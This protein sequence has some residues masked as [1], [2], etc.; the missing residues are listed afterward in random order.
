MTPY[1]S[2]DYT[3]DC[4]REQARK[5]RESGKYSKVHVHKARPE[6]INGQ[7]VEYGRVYV[8]RKES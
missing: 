5:C 4:C 6:R 3:M 7:L 8:E 2:E 1:T